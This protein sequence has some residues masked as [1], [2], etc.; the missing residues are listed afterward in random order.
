[1]TDLADNEHDRPLST[2]NS[3][4]IVKTSNPV[5][6]TQQQL[7]TLEGITVCVCVRERERERERERREREE[8][9]KKK[10]ISKR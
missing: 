6:H 7:G 2:S 4:H 1:M 9:E 3:P 8:R 10:K 5:L